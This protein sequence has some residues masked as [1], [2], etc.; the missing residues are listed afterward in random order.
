M[1]APITESP[2]IHQAACVSYFDRSPPQGVC[3]REWREK[4]DATT[5]T[6]VTSLGY[7]MAL[8]IPSGSGATQRTSMYGGNGDY[9]HRRLRNLH[10]A[11]RSRARPRYRLRGVSR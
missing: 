9:L 11:S 5:R 8:A 2:M 7:P 3:N 6:E 1:T 10:G 4:A